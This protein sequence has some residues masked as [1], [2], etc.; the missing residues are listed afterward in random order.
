MSCDIYNACG[1]MFHREVRKEV[2]R[3]ERDRSCHPKAGSID[4]G[5]GSDRCCSD[6]G[7]GLWSCRE[8]EGSNGRCERLR[9]FYRYFSEDLFHQ[10]AKRQRRVFDRIWVCV[11]CK[12]GYSLLMNSVRSR[13]SPS[14]KRN[15][16]DET[17]VVSLAFC[18]QDRWYLSGDQLRQD[19]EHWLCPPDPS[20]SHNFVRR[21]RY[22]GT[23]AWFFE[24][25]ALT[26]W[27]TRGSLLW[28]HG[29]RM[30]FKSP[31]SV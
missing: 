16:Q 14:V 20:T 15:K 31:T 11:S 25:D 1:S 9:K 2:F 13:S 12:V 24:S 22:I 4:S 17:F 8:Y 21:A 3:G 19:V 6:L 27:K 26:E 10:M 29:K 7:C 23:A 28:I 18:C 30:Y 5:R